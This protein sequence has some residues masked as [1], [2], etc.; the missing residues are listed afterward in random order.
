MPDLAPLAR[1]TPGEFKRRFKGSPVLRAT[2]DGF[3]RNAVIALGNSGKGQAVPVLEDAIKDESPI[4]RAHAAWALGRIATAGARHAL[5]SARAKEGIQPVLDEIAL[6]LIM[7]R[8]KDPK[9]QSPN[10]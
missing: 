4:V 6:A 7:Q 1:I 9:M 5:E 10:Q 3:V 2:R 8:H